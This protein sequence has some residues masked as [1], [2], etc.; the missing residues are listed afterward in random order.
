M[1]QELSNYGQM[2]F[3]LPHDL[4]PL[5]S[6]G[7]FYKNKKKSVKVGYLTATDENILLN[8]SQGNRESVVLSLLRNKL[9]ESD[10]RPDELLTGD[11]EAI[12]IFLRNTA[13]GPEYEVSL[14]D[15]QTGKKFSYTLLLD[16]L[17][18][19]KTDNKP[20]EDGLF[21]V[22]LPKSGDEVKLRPLSLADSLDIEKMVESYPTNRVAPKVTWK[23]NKQITSINGETDK[24]QIAKYIE[25]MPIMDSKFVRTFLNQNEPRLDLQKEVT[26]PSGE[27]VIVDIT[28]GVEFFRPFY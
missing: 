12:L 3:N 21:V 5:P 19:K 7:V 15:P 4:V 9:Y 10:L 27:K 26:A 17:N 18:I 11:V 13:F 2:N 25:T 24:G 22:K 6:N 20:T 28:F 1:E 16:E 23:L 8:T 14:T